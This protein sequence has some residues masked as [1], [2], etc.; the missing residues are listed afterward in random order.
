MP[1]RVVHAAVLVIFC[2]LLPPAPALSEE[3]HALV[4][5]PGRPAAPDFRLIDTQSK[6]H[7]LADY[8]GKVV[9]V[10]FWA[11]WCEPCRKEM[12][13]LQRAWEHLRDRG[14]VVLAINWGDD[15]PTIDRFLQEVKVDFPVLLGWDDDMMAQWSIKGLPMSFVIDPQGRLAYRAAGELAWDEPALLA[16]LLAL[17]EKP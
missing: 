9:L 15:A 2:C 8:H 3:L 7:A 11:T 1:S 4:D 10:N 16:K 17:K 13:A 12:P 6:P 14:A 5:V